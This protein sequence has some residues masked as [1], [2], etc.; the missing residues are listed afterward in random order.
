[1]S[2]S[3]LGLSF[4]F[5]SLL[6]LSSP[7]SFFQFLLFSLFVLF[8]WLL[9]LPEKGESAPLVL[10]RVKVLLVPLRVILAKLLNVRP[11]LYGILGI[12]PVRFFLMYLMVRLLRLLMPRCFLAKRVLLVPPRFQALERFLTFGLDKEFKRRCLSSLILSREKSKA[13]PSG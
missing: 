2:L 7:F 10:L 5:S 4:S 9:L 6:F 11:S 1:M 8:Q 13:G 12:L 3:F